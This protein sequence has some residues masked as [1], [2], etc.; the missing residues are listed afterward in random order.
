[1]TQRITLFLAQAL[2][3]AIAVAIGWGTLSPPGSGTPLPLTDKQLHFLAFAA[4]AL[5]LGWV[6]PRWALW[7]IPVALAFGAAIEL[8]QPFVGRSGEWGDLMAD[9]LGILAGVLP[10]QLRHRMLRPG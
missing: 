8:I 2:T 4:L 3:C 10:G 5:P 1:M 6:R 9:G 7:L